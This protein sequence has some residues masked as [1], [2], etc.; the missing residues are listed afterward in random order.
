[1]HKVYN[2]LKDYKGRVHFMVSKLY[3]NKATK[4]NNI[5]VRADHYF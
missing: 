4:N 1:M 2:T 3:F 5:K